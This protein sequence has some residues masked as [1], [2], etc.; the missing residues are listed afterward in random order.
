MI[1]M[2]RLL[3][4]LFF[5]LSVIVL[6]HQTVKGYGFNTL[7]LCEGL[8]HETLFLLGVGSAIAVW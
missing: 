6:V 8:H 7:Q 5:S 4:I 3:S 1:N 2:R